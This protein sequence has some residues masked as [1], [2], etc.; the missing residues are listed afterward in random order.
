MVLPDCFLWDSGRNYKDLNRGPAPGR[1]GPCRK[2]LTRLHLSYRLLDQPVVILFC[3]VA[4]H[5]LGSDETGQVGRPPPDLL[6]RPA[7]FE[8]DLAF[9]SL[10][11]R[12]RFGA[13][14]L[15]HL[16]AQA[17]RVS[18]AAGDDGLGLDARVADDL[19]G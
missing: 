5:A 1:A 12:V 18:A 9:R 13:R 11:D 7:G 4:L 19:L 8:L 14:L 2:L 16:L 6:Q 15:L 10:D 17:F 3:Q